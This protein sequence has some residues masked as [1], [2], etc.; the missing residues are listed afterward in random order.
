MYQRCI[1]RIIDFLIAAIMFPFFLILSLIV[2]IFIAIDDGFPIFFK[3]YRLGKD[4]KS[5]RIYKY[6]SMMK[7]APDYRNEDGSTFN[8]QEDPRV[9]RVGKILR[10]TSL[11]EIPQLLNILK[12][13]MSLIGPRPDLPEDIQI[14]NKYQKKKLSVRP[15]ITGYSQAYYRNS[16]SQDLKFDNDAYYSEH[17]SFLFDLKI[18]FKTIQ[19]VLGQKNIYTNTKE[20][21]KENI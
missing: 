5:F 20:Q 18:F 16:I 1:K 2:G 14:Y 4:G 12:G 15:G 9:T 19:S 8:S 21:T 3:S 10:R 11:D 17:I 13:E 6:R 7:N